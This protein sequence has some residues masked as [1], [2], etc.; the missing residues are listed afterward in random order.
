ML[1]LEWDTFITAS[2]H[3]EKLRE[4]WR[5]GDRKIVRTRSWERLQQNNISAHAQ[6]AVILMNS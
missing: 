4:H 2:S 3:A 6:R 1:S 5:R